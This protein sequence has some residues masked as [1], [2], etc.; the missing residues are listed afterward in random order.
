VLFENSG[1]SNEYRVLVSCFVLISFPLMAILKR[2][3]E[4]IYK[5]FGIV[6]VIRHF[7]PELFLKE[8]LRTSMLTVKIHYV[9]NS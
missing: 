3:L 1:I 5:M 6:I 8:L 4:L 2:I 7:I 9:D